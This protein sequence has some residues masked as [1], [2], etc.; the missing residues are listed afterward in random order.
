MDRRQAGQAALFDQLRAKYVI[1][2]EEFDDSS[3]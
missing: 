2:I 1:T 3:L